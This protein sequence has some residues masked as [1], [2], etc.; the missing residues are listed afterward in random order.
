MTTDQIT[1]EDINLGLP[2]PQSSRRKL[3]KKI[4]AKLNWPFLSHQI[5]INNSVIPKINQLSQNDENLAQ[6]LNGISTVLDQIQFSLAHH[7]SV[8]ERFEQTL[9][10]HDAFIHNNE[11]SLTANAKKME[12][13]QE[14]LSRVEETL[15]SYAKVL[16]HHDEVCTRQDVTLENH[17]KYISQIK[18]VSEHFGRL[19]SLIEL[20]QQ[21]S[22][23]RLHDTLGPLQ[24]TINDHEK[25]LLEQQ[26]ALSEG[27]RTQQEAIA[28]GLRTQQEATH[29]ELKEQQDA[30]ND[31]IQRSTEGTLSASEQLIEKEIKSIWP[32]LAQV[33]L[34]VNEV[35]R[36]LPD[37][38]QKESLAKLPSSFAGLYAA[39]EDTFRGTEERI[40]SRLE[41]YLPLLTQ[42]SAL[43]PILDIGCG[44]GELLE[45]LSQHGMDA[46]GVDFLQEN[47]ERCTKK[48][49]SALLEDAF[50]HLQSVKPNSL[51]AITAIHI[52]EH[53]DL[54]HQIE[55][56]DRSLAALAPG[57]VL[58]IETPNPENVTI[59]SCNFYLDP[60]HIKPIPPPLLEFFLN[61]RGFGDV[62]T[63]RHN[64]GLFL[65]GINGIAENPSAD[66][67]TITIAKEI[68]P[69]FNSAQDYAVIGKK[70]A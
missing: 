59:G 13:H 53:V 34:F 9:G 56:I 11:G 33:D 49:L 37:P 32:R 62:H 41:A 51:G 43:G 19:N 58:I 12:H 26:N 2:V 17:E 10:H 52:I 4:V 22:F 54:E 28:E 40:K 21:Q 14:V 20:V 29:E 55:L 31:L 46:Y 66:T 44:R 36:S 63:T 64:R 30:L 16:E 24:T 25:R 27:L 67:S 5:K 60:T 35:K 15:E 6:T 3:I 57:G 39:F 18:E 65:A 8:L 50:E 42:V 70:I 23:T 48:G 38:P 7:T 68:S 47:I 69:F 45:L 1:P 61:A